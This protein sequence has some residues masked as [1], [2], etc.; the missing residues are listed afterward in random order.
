[1]LS[2]LRASTTPG[3]ISSISVCSVQETTPPICLSLCSIRDSELV[4]RARLGFWQPGHPKEACRQCQEQRQGNENRSV[5]WCVFPFVSNR[6]CVDYQKPRWLGR[7][8]LL[9]SSRWHRC[10]PCYFRGCSF[11][12]CH[13]IRAGWC[14][15]LHL[16]TLLRTQFPFH[17]VSISIG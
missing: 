2:H 5:R 3:L 11:Q 6:T 14:E 12:C 7:E 4:Q 13:D 1:M 8:Y 10:E 9:P 16:P 17:Q 15:L